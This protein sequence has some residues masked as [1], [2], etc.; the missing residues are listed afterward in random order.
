MG[1]CS[2][3]LAAVKNI[4]HKI[5]PE[6][7]VVLDEVLAF[8][9]KIKALEANPAVALVASLIPGEAAVQAVLDSAIDKLTRID[10]VLKQKDTSLK[11]ADFVAEVQQLDPSVQGKQWF[12][13]ASLMIQALDPTGGLSTTESEALA[14]LKIVTNK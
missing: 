1:L 7:E 11:L 9:G 10:A 4:W 2:K 5:T 8:T 6:L 13:L 3:G 12:N 14:I